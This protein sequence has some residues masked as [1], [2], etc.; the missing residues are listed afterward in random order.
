M[1]NEHLIES[2]AHGGEKVSQSIRSL[3]AD[4]LLSVPPADANVGRWSIQQLVLHLSDCEL[5]FCDRMK[6]V[7][8][9]DNPTLLAFD[10]MRWTAALH[11]HDQ[12]VQDA[13]QLIDLARRQMAIVLRNLPQEAFA[14]SGT[15]SQ[16]GRRTLQD[17]VQSAVDHLEH[18][19]KFV[20]GKR[21]YMGKEMW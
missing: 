4:D 3:T 20:H 2:Y 13:V 15:H 5:V 14:R 9:E 12:S 18:H 6:R 7:I 21:A 10:E 19:L 17:L 11:Y 8:A 16:T 1:A